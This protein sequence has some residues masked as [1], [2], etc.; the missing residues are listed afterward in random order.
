M[1]E[2]DFKKIYKEYGQRLYGFIIWLT[3]HRAASD[4]ILQN[5]FIN[6]WKYQTIP[7]SE[8]ELQRWLLLLPEMALDHAK[9]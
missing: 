9:S 4:D 6:I 5:V 8:I 1:T 3:R 7:S 2:A